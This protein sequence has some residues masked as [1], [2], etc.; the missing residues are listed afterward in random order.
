MPFI[1]PS[2][3]SI[4][5]PVDS[6]QRLI[7]FFNTG[8]NPAHRWSSKG[9]WKAVYYLSDKQINEQLA[10]KAFEKVLDRQWVNYDG[11]K[12]L[13]EDFLSKKASAGLDKKSKELLMPI[14]NRITTHDWFLK[15]YVYSERLTNF[16]KACDLLR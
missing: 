11:E 9:D 16:K 7:N 4:I 1:R 14:C 6:F 10:A 13:L 15:S 2:K 8:E 12:V 3:N 5:I